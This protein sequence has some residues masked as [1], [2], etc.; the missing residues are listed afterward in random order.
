MFFWVIMGRRT[1]LERYNALKNNSFVV[2]QEQELFFKLKWNWKKMF[3]KNKNPIVLELACGKWE[4]SIWMAKQF[5]DKNFLWIDIKWERIFIWASMIE[6]FW[7][8]NVWFIRMNIHDLKNIFTQ[9]EIDDIWLIHPDPRPKNSDRNRR[10]TAPKF[11]WIYK[12]ILK[13]WWKLR[14]KTDDVDLFKYSLEKFSAFW[15]NIIDLTFDLYSSVLYKD[16]YWIK[17][18]YEKL[19]VEKWRKINYVVCK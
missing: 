4:Y 15:F 3:F 6:E 13:L 16:H 8:K 18:N 7:L 19:F 2:D 10:L 11:L 14:L 17:T 5:P 12:T 9:W 1:K